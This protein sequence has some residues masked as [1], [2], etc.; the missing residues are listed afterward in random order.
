M[1]GCAAACAGELQLLAHLSRR[2][3]TEVDGAVQI[4]VQG[5]LP[6]RLVELLQGEGCRAVHAAEVFEHTHQRAVE[7]KVEGSR[8]CRAHVRG[9][10]QELRFGDDDDAE[11]GEE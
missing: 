11:G 4:L 5:V 6:M 8:E 10:G 1:R 2:S 9:G 7:R 3:W